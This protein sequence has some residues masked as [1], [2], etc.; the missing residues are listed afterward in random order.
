M[1]VKA[2]LFDYIK[3]LGKYNTLETKYNVLVEEIKNDTFKKLLDVINEPV[4]IERLKKE[5]K[6]L[7]EKIKT[8]QEI[9]KEGKH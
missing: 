2:G 6:R 1:E 8:L 3:L 5:N 7:R 9:I 4:R